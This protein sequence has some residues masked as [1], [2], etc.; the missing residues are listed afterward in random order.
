MY[1]TNQPTIRA[2]VRDRVLR[3]NTADL[4]VEAEL[5]LVEWLADN[6]DDREL[7]MYGAGLQRMADAIKLTSA[8][9]GDEMN[10]AKRTL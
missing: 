6:P 7:L 4:C 3:A 10:P 1:E 8:G 9:K 5:L 2:L